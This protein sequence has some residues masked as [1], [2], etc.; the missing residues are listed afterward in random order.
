MFILRRLRDLVH[1]KQGR[2]LHLICL[3]SPTAFCKVDTRCLPTVL[4]RFGTPEKVIRVIEALVDNPLFKVTMQGEESETQEQGTGIRQGRTLSPFM[5]T[6]ILSVIMEDVDKEV[7]EQ[8]PVATTPSMSVMDL[9][10]AGDTALLAR[11]AEVAIKLLAATEREAAKYGLLLNRSKT[12]RLAYNTEENIQF[13][14]GQQVPRVKTVGY[15][16]TVM[17]E[18]GDPG[19]ELRIRLARALGKCKALKPI[20]ATKSLPVKLTARV[21]RSCVFS[22]LI[23][24]LHTMYFGRS[25]EHKLDA[26]QIGC[27][28]RALGIK[29][30]YAAKLIGMEAVSNREVAEAAGAVPLSLEIQ[31]FRYRLLGHV[32]RRGDDPSRATTYDRLGQPKVLSGKTSGGNTERMG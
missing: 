7:R 18:G 29:S 13:A 25:W 17:D 30:T 21:L 15:L 12:C 20:W 27:L 8:H 2:A 4:R 23:Y 10:Y 28:R 11:Y 14:D 3:D 16:G 24:G 5:F 32:L 1:A 31:K 26:L 9:E 19:E 22:G 6:L